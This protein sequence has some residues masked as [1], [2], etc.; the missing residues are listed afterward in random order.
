M[1]ENERQ[2]SNELF[3]RF[4]ERSRWFA[5]ELIVIVVGVLIA[6]AIDEWRG[7]VE[8]SSNEVDYIRQLI[9]DLQMT[10]D[11]IA[12]V[13]TY[14][15]SADHAAKKLVAAFESDEEVAVNTLRTLLRDALGFDN[16][17]PV[18]GTA[19][20]LISTGDLRLIGNASTRT[21]ITQ[22]LSHSRDYLLIWVY[23]LE[24]N[25]TDTYMQFRNIAAMHGILP[26]DIAGASRSRSNPNIETFMAS[27]DA[28]LAAVGMTRIQGAFV[29][30][31]DSTADNARRLRETLEK[32]LVSE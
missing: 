31:R 18:L 19:E 28:Y 30:Y 2:P 1:N 32:L 17:V 14:N 4:G 25:Y 15:A 29:I 13:A 9:A 21:E 23:R 10:E 3:G 26:Q 12:A 8:K 24:E 22:Y 16:P 27:S 6:L 5:A 11:S 7:N 20:T